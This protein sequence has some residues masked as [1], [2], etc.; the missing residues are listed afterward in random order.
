M[1]QNHVDLVH[2]F[3]LFVDVSQ[4]LSVAWNYATQVRLL[5]QNGAAFDQSLVARIRK[6]SK[7]T[8]DNEVGLSDRKCSRVHDAIFCPLSD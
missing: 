7:K 1:E 2:F 6:S 3:C 8:I 5:V 4:L